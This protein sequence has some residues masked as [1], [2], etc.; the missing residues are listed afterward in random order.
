MVK[1][2]KSSNLRHFYIFSLGYLTLS[3]NH[4]RYLSLALTETFLG[5]HSERKKKEKKFLKPSLKIFESG[6]RINTINHLEFT[7]SCEVILLFLKNIDRYS[8]YVLTETFI[9]SFPI[10]R[11]KVFEDIFRNKFGRA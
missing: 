11:K 4:K 10:R 3:Q 5:S 2:L 8:S 9:G 6:E 1:T 7:V